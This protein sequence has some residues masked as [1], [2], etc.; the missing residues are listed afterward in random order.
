MKWIW[1]VLSLLLLTVTALAAPEKGLLPEIL[2]GE[3]PSDNKS[4]TAEILVT[5]SETKAIQSLMSILKKKK[6]QPQEASLYYRLAELYMRRAKSGRFFDLNR[7]NKNVLRFA[8]PWLKSQSAKPQLELAL[9]VYN[10]IQKDFPRFEQMDSV[11]FNSAFANQQ[12][13]RLPQA[14]VLYKKLVNAH[15]ESPLVPDA[16]LAMGEMKYNAGQFTD[17]LV[18]FQQIENYPQSRLYSY[19]IYKSGWTYY[20]MQKTEPAISKLEQV[21]EYHKKS[22]NVSAH[23][24]RG[25]ALRDLGLFFAD[26]R[27]PEHAHSYFKG[28]TEDE[29]EL[30][31]TLLSLGKLY[32]SH[33]RQKEATVFLNAFINNESEAQAVG[34]M[35]IML[36]DMNEL[37]KNRPQVLTHLQALTELC[38]APSS[39]LVRNQDEKSMETCRKDLAEK[40][41]ELAKKWWEL[42]QKNLHH[43]EIADLTEKAFQLHLSRDNADKP[44]SLSRFAYA[45]LLFQR[46]KYSEASREYEKVSQQKVAAKEGAML[47]DALYGAIVSLEKTPRK[48]KKDDRKIEELCE[49]YLKTYPKGSQIAQV[50]LK[51]GFIAYEDGRI[52][53]A[54]SFLVPLTTHA[55]IEVSKRAQDLYLDIL[56]LKKDYSGLQK[57]AEQYAGK[58]RDGKRLT[59][60]K[61]IERESSYTRISLISDK[62]DHLKA[63][64]EYRK[65]GLDLDDKDLAEKSLLS[66]IGLYFKAGKVYEGALLSLQFAE[67]FPNNTNKLAILETAAKTFADMGLF[68]QASQTLEKIA[69]LNPK[70]SEEYLLMAADFYNLE[71]K[72]IEARRI[73]KTFINPGDKTRRSAILAKL[74]QT[75]DNPQAP[76]AV[77]LKNQMV[78]MGIEPWASQFQIEKLKAQFERGRFSEAFEMAKKIMTQSPDKESRAQARLYQARILEQEFIAQSVKA[79]IDRLALVLAL[80]TEK[81]EKAQQA[82]LSVMQMSSNAKLSLQALYGLKRTYT[83]FAENL[84]T[85]SLPEDLTENEKL[86]LKSELQNLI[87]PIVA[88][89]KETDEKIASF[90]KNTAILTEAEVVNFALLD[91]N[92]S[93]APHVTPRLSEHAQI[94]APMARGQRWIANE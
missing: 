68:I 1:I 33:S 53:R 40:T 9:S 42:W 88:K 6:G 20:N 23:N 54:E 81:L 66:S 38:K 48:E 10:K 13:G 72:T 67:K 47:H 25:E 28:L 69:P 41:L 62:G 30:G 84:T 45:E 4:A 59:Q 11:Y 64:E 65:F 50:Q 61:K 37:L 16:Y 90:E 35:H 80:K 75:Y 76:E 46:E 36:T 70:K 27:K 7:D 58:E 86:G 87:N 78:S 39:Y 8:A 51:L 21:V 32:D 92:E 55:Q 85:L 74:I 31:E 19:G 43:Q 94:F 3:G 12:L 14:E 2:P 93:V 73:L 56:N 24:L 49:L 17:A 5:E 82:Y 71:K 44:D 22:Q 29:T 60:L 52:P 34:P 91:P 79:K 83:N 57:S 77:E 15:P 26:V 18:H 63:A 89:R